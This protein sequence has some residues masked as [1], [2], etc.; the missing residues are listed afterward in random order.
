VNDV[1]Q[2]IRKTGEALAKP[3]TALP[4]LGTVPDHSAKRIRELLPWK[5][6]P[7]DLAAAA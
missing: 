2:A 6:R 7:P 4:R 3:A 1:T 5:R